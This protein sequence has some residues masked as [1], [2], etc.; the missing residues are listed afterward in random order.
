MNA[1]TTVDHLADPVLELLP[2]AALAPSETKVQARRRRHYSV[3]FLAEMGESIA[4]NGVLQPLLVRPL[5]AMRGL[6][7]YEIVAGE[8]RWRGAE[9]AGL[10]HLPC[11]VR[12]MSD[13]QVLAAQL[14]ENLQREGLRELD[15]AE[16]Y[17]E[18]MQLEHLTAAQAAERI[19]KKSLRHVF[20][21]LKLLQL[22]P[23]AMAALERGDLD[24]SRAQLVAGVQPEKLQAKA[25]K[26]AL[27]PGW[28][29]N[30]FR[31]SVRDLAAQL[32]GK[33]MTVSLKTTPFDL[34]DET[35]HEAMDAKTMRTIMPFTGS[36]TQCPNRSGNALDA[37]DAD[38]DPDVC[39]HV[40]CF[41]FRSRVQSLRRAKEAEAVGAVVLRGEAAAKIFPDKK[42]VVGY[43]DLD[44][45]CDNDQYAEPMPED[46]DTGNEAADDAAN[47]AAYDAWQERADAYQRRTYRQL[48]ADVV[49]DVV[50]AEDP[51]AKRLRELIDAKTARRLLKDRGI[52]APAGL[53]APP[54]KPQPR[55]D[56][57]AE[58]AA[59]EA[60]RKAEQEREAK[61]LD[62]RRRVMA[63]VWPRVKG[64]ATRADL[65]A[66]AE[67]TMDDHARAWEVREGLKHVLK[68]KP[69][70]GNLKDVELQRLLI[71]MPAASCLASSYSK[72]D[73][74]YALAKRFKVDAA[75][76][77]RGME[78]PATK[79]A[80][81]KAKGADPKIKPGKPARAK[82]KKKGAKK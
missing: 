30:K 78:D 54:P 31:Y 59:N 25:L 63:E 71:L 42:H 50:L 45:V 74:L 43:V 23:D 3:T 41:D 12:D 2:R 21:R 44:A 16:G 33:R 8:R 70:P 67:M 27:E 18:L 37:E 60:K 36:C 66:L 72:P 62:F 13:A 69:L 51:H 65:V 7:K 68:S 5:A 76:I 49:I 34:A 47:E 52:Q 55:Y 79:D 61:E 10:E 46:I 40:A 4:A 64:P 22:P 73:L 56:Y 26:L 82:A 19:G 80:G 28:G 39:T 1:P 32:A 75:K 48:L 11:F 35:F 57:E 14:E 9:H 38:A 17:R 58:R 53:G 6:A 77:K 20:N 81:D 15:E 29:S 24:V